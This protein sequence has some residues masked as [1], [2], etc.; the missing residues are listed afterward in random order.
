MGLID[1]MVNATN[2]RQWLEMT[3]ENM[4]KA[5][6]SRQTAVQIGATVAYAG[7][8]FRVQTLIGGMSMGCHS[9]P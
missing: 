6:E 9:L 5:E 3:L 7:F 1:K 4:H 2:K 8:L